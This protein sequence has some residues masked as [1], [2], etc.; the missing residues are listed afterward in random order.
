MVLLQVGR[1]SVWFLSSNQPNA[2]ECDR[3]TLATDRPLVQVLHVRIPIASQRSIPDVCAEQVFR[4]RILHVRPGGD[5]VRADGQRGPNRP[6]DQDLSSHDQVPVLQVR[7]V[8]EHRNGGRP[9][10]P[11]NRKRLFFYQLNKLEI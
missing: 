1:L 3:K 2:T 8:V 5:S 9:L 10:P 6:D 7:S 4:R 11:A